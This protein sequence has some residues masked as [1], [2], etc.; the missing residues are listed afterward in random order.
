M[1]PKAEQL[2][3]QKKVRVNFQTGDLYDFLCRDENN[4]DMIVYN[5]VFYMVKEYRESLQECYKRLNSGGCIF[6]TARTKWFYAALLLKNGNFEKAGQILSSNEGD[7]GG[8]V[9]F[10]WWSPDEIEKLM[11]ETGFSDIKMYGIG[12][13]SGIKGDPLDDICKPGDLEPEDTEKLRE[14]ELKAAPVFYNSSRY[15]LICGK[16]D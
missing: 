3:A 13:F 10:N 11:S 8:M 6:L 15:L 9:Q 14:I 2:M 7:L 4:Y 16:K 12:P 1:R 5:E